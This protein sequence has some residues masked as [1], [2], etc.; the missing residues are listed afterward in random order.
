V[1]AKDGSV[2]EVKFTSCGA[3]GLMVKHS[4]GFELL[5]QAGHWVAAPIVNNTRSSVFIA[6]SALSAV[7]S[8]AAP[9]AMW[10]GVRY[11]FYQSP[12]LPT[13]GEHMCAVYASREGLPAPPFKIMFTGT[14]NEGQEVP[15][16]RAPATEAE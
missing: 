5:N 10:K 4:V 2:V 9:T 15:R 12:C 3:E 7:S 14:E 6:P 1:E 8:S 13:A 11:N 16:E